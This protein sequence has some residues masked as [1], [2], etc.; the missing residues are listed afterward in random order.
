LGYAV[1][2]PGRLP[3]HARSRILAVKEISI[4]QQVRIPYACLAGGPLDA[5][6]RRMYRLKYFQFMAGGADDVDVRYLLTPLAPCGL[7]P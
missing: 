4:F 1:K 7:K 6:G 2:G 3:V 5:I